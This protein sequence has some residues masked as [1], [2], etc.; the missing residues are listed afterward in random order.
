MQPRQ[1]AGRAGPAPRR[2]QPSLQRDDDRLGLLPFADVDDF[3]AK[4]NDTVDGLAA[5]VST[6]D[7]RPIFR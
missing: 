7:L 1:G 3:A 6:R 4:A 2:A 5:G